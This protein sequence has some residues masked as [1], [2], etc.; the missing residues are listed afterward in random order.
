MTARSFL[1]RFLADQTG[2]V[3]EFA[4]LLPLI[5]L[6]MLGLIDAGRYAYDFNRGEKAT[7]IG[8]RVAVVT[9]PLV[10]Q[11]TTYT[12]SGVTVG[13]VQ[14]GQGDR[15]PQGALGTI[16]CTSTGCTC[17][18]A[19]CLG[20]TLTLDTAAFAVMANRIKQIWPKV[21]DADITVEY[22]GSGLGYAGNP[23]GMDIAPFVT[24][25]LANMDFTSIFLFGTTVGLPDFHYTLTMEDG[26][27]VNY[28]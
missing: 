14:L 23:S 24:V 6:F 16:T 28:N 11:L 12:F 13:G 25:R 10:Q 19:P 15:I 2:A 7:Q 5:M 20:G 22:T 26:A 8:A 9:D 3:A 27:G 4:L 17:T 1:R 18:V 21:E